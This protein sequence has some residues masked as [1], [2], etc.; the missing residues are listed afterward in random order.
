MVPKKNNDVLPLRIV[1][2]L[3][4]LQ[5]S[6]DLCKLPYFGQF[7]V[8]ETQPEVEIKPFCCFDTLKLDEVCMDVINSRILSKF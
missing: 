3:V 8:V 5:E 2:W 6:D 1:H 4:W 7:Q